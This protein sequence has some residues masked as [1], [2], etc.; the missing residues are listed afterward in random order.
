MAKCV[1]SHKIRLTLLSY[2]W[3]RLFAILQYEIVSQNNVMYF[4]NT[5]TVLS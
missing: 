2:V 5:E 3:Y 4:K 1:F